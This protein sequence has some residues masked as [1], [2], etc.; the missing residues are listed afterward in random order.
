MALNTWLLNP[1]CLLLPLVALI[2]RLRVNVVSM[3]DKQKVDATTE[4]TN[5]AIQRA[6]Q[7]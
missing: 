3:S 5:L 2:S 1:H 7:M 4:S 6:S